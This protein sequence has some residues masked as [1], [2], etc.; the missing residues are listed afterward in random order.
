MKRGGSYRH[1][2]RR[3]VSPIRIVEW[4]ML[5]PRCRAVLMAAAVLVLLDLGLLSG[6]VEN[7]PRPVAASDDPVL[8]GAGDIATC[9]YGQAEATARLIDGI[10]GTV[11]TLGDNAY[12]QGTLAEFESC[13]GPSWGRHRHRTFPSAGNHEYLTPDASG[14]F[15][16]FG[17]A[18]G[19]PGKSYYSY[20]LGTWH[21]VVLNS[22]CPDGCHPGSEQEQWLRAD[23]AAHPSSCI[24]AYWHYPLFSSGDWGNYVEV[25]PLWQALY[26]AGADVILNGHE[27]YYE[28]F[29]PQD[30]Y[31]S[32]D[33]ER[34]IRQFI[35]GTG[36]SG[37]HNFHAEVHPNSEV[38]D[39]GTHGVL[40][41]TLRGETYS[42]EFIPIPGRTFRDSGQGSCHGNL[43]LDW[44]AVTW[45]SVSVPD[46][47]SAGSQQVIPTTVQNA[48]LEAWRAAV[49]DERRFGKVF[50]SYH[51][52]SA[53]SDTAV[54]WD[55]IRTALPHDIGPG[56]AV[57]M[58]MEVIAPPEPGSYRLQI[59]L[60]Q[61]QIT[62]FERRGAASLTIP[63][64][65]W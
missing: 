56:E 3:A 16:Y 27:H 33:K 62:W 26:D 19:E 37:F 6:R 36:G 43:E 38:R 31:G 58:D 8:V 53:E 44:Y 35:V 45:H 65:V 18:A 23:L 41:L 48:G 11:F 47:M 9:P 32:R 14:Y 28:R 63:V 10:P 29:A 21:V 61:E 60:V 49:P 34:G 42:W 7:G 2:I 1:A 30:P 15:T 39:T 25:R 54:I 51:W 52:L 57:S 24:L 59:T 17:P 46:T 40:K 55:G 12:S 5:D 20:D 50:V 64:T 13:Y 22:M 4:M